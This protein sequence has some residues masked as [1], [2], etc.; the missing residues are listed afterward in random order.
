M[1]QHKAKDEAKPI[2]IGI[3][4]G[5]FNGIG[6][7][8]I[9][10]AL[11]DNRITELFTP[12]IYCIPKVLSYHRKNMNL[13]DF[14]YKIINN[15]RQLEHS[16]VNVV[17]LSNEEVKVEHGLSTK[18]AGE[19]AYQALENAV[20]DLKNSLIDVLV[21]AP[22]NKANIQSEKFHFPG[23]TEYLTDRF[24]SPSSLMLL[25]LQNLRIGTVTGHIPINQVPSAITEELILSKIKILDASLKNDFGIQRPKIAILGL[26]PH[27]GDEGVIGDEETKVIQPAI[28]AAKKQGSLVYGPFPADGFFGSSQFTK[29]DGILAMYHDQ[30][31]I[32]FKTLAFK[33][34]VNFTA[35]LPI[36]RT[37]PAHG[38]A[39]EIAGKDLAS[40]DS[41]RQ[42]MFLAIDIFRNRKMMAEMNAN[43]LP[44]SGANERN[45]RNYSDSDSL[46]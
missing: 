40:P 16:K 29:Y 30:G 18:I 32:P 23:H 7:E 17:S 28:A 19:Y 2:R 45:S 42:A 6:Y 44:S 36:V 3:T 1:I 8:V 5:D 33:G 26:N 38:T 15:A 13:E 46:Q 43:P 21:T 9:L 27:A 20:A 4:H 39:Y 24:G 25:V 10:K 41:I 35:G 37:S 34:G 31:L 12:V 11:D 14:N 22:V